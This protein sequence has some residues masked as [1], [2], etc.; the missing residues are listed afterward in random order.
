MYTPNSYLV[1]RVRTVPL[2]VKT[3][4]ASECRLQRRPLP[5]RLVIKPECH[6]F[7]KRLFKLLTF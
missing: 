1:L 3:S 2:L 5:V 7:F 6:D 4:D